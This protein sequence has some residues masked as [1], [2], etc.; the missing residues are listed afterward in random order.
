MEDVFKLIDKNTV[1]F[2]DF[3]KWLF[4]KLNKNEQQFRNFGK[5][6]NK[7]KY[8]LLLEYLEHKKVNILEALCYY[9]YKSSNMAYNFEQLCCYLIKEEFYRIEHKKK[10]NYTPF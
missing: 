3:R 1:T 5:Y 8:P 2:N 7:L 10:I 6:P 4:L 9:N